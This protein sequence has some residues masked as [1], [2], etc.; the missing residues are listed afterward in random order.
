MGTTKKQ[1]GFSEKAKSMFEKTEKAL[2]KVSKNIVEDAKRHNSYLVVSDKKGN[3]KK[4]HAK[5]L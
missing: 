3:I 1:V 4:I 5:D 2:G